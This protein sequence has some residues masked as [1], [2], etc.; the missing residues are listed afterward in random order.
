MHEQNSYNYIGEIP[1]LDILIMNLYFKSTSK[2]KSTMYDYINS[3]NF[4]IYVR[5]NNYTK[6]IV[7]FT[8]KY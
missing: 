1:Q 4:M 5:G 7:V 2:A 8:D 3:D 6:L